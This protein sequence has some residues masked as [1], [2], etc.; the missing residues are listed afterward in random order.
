MR[1]LRA[2][3]LGL[4]WTV[5]LLACAPAP[6]DAVSIA[7]SS[8]GRGLV[9][10]WTFDDGSGTTV[11]DRSGFGHDGQLTGG[12]WQA[13][14]R[15]GGALLLAPGDSVTIPN[16]PSATPDWSASVWLR[17][18]AADL[19][20]STA[21]ISTL[22]SAETVFA[23]GWQLHLDN[24]PGY[25]RLDVAYWV[26]EPVNDYVVLLCKCI[27]TERWIHLTATFDTTARR[28]SLYRD[29]TLVD[30][31]T[32]PSPI[33][34]GDSTLYI[35]RWNQNGRNLSGTI[36]DFAIWGRALSADEVEAATLRPPPEAP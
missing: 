33:L 18:T 7:N 2:P 36:D 10:H 22:L 3:A 9:A 28:I 13:R 6:I 15:F 19:A 20:A 27:E 21:D 34:P 1:R 24:R 26:G 29:A 5:C 32:L 35:G 16:F 12:T 30:G 4:S 14:G 17:V 25:E 31:T 11:A 8:L 23:G